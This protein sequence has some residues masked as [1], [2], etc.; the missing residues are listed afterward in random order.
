MFKSKTEQNKNDEKYSLTGITVKIH[1]NDDGFRAT[2]I[3]LK[4]IAASSSRRSP[5]LS[6]QLRAYSDILSDVLSRGPHRSQQPSFMALSSGTILMFDP[7]N[8][9][10]V[11]IKH[12]P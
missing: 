6:E 10:V 2:A 9:A 3:M 11:F 5:P 8:W 1:T 12:T 4:S 7:R